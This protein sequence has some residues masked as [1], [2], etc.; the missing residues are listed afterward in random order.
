MKRMNVIS[1]ANRRAHER[2]SA[3]PPAISVNILCLDP[4]PLAAHADFVARLGVPGIAVSIDGVEDAG[5]GAGALLRDAGLVVSTLTHRAFAFTSA[6]ETQAARERL[7]RTI[8]VAHDIGAQSITL[9]TGGR[10]TLTWREAAARF[11][12]GISPCAEA[13][14]AAGVALAIEPTSHLYADASIVHRLADLVTLARMAGTELGI[15]IFACWFDSDIEAA[16]HEAAPLC[17]L[18][19]VSDHVA[20][21]RGL[22]CRAVPGDGMAQL[23]RL[24]PAIITAG[25]A[26]WFD[27]EVIGP[28]LHGE[29]VESGLRR[30][31]TMVEAWIGA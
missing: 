15:D 27:L 14:R 26:G 4:A 10:G 11:A 29:G 13:A 6:A 17:R 1:A 21:D 30:A 9:T 8:T 5:G 28:R 31:I 7:A 16:I 24:L 3:M 20:G 2:I 25:Y 22:P 18:V 19:Q 12:E 23:D